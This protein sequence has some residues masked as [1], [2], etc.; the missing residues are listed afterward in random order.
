MDPPGDDCIAEQKRRAGTPARPGDPQ[1]FAAPSP[2]L[3]EGRFLARAWRLTVWYRIFS[4][5]AVAAVFPL[6]YVAEKKLVPIAVVF[7]AGG[8]L[9]AL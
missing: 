6:I 4:F 8:A 3:G 1:P 7:V 2:G 9:M 5:A